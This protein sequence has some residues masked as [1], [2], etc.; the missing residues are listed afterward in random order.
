MQRRSYSY[1]FCSLRK[2]RPAMIRAARMLLTALILAG[3]VSTELPALPVQAAPLKAPFTV[4]TTA[5]TVD[6]SPGNGVCADASG[7]CSLRAAISE[8]N[9]LAGADTITLDAGVYQLT[10]L[11][12]L[13]VNEDG[14]STGDLDI[15][16]SLTLIGSAAGNTIIQAGSNSGDGIDKVIAANPACTDGVNITISN[17]T[18][19]YGRNTQPV[20]PIYFSHT[21]GGVDWCGGSGNGSFTLRDAAVIQNT[22]VNGYGGGLNV[23]SFSG[24]TGTV[25]IYNVTFINNNTLSTTTTSSGGALNIFGDSPVVVITNSSF[26]NNA[27]TYSN[28]GAIFYRPSFGGSLQIDNSFFS[29]NYSR[30]GGAISLEPSTSAST[31]LIQHSVISGNIADEAGGGLSLSPG[32]SSTTPMA[33]TELEIYGNNAGTSGGGIYANG[34]NALLTYSR[35]VYN[36]DSTGGSGLYE[37]ARING[38][39]NV[40]AENNWWG[41]STGP[42]AVPC[43]RAV[44]VGGPLDF[45]PWLRDQL[46]SSISPLAVNQSSTLTS[47]FLTNSENT[48]VPAANLGQIVNQP[49]TWGAT[50]GTLSGTQANILAGGTATGELSGQRSWDCRHLHEGG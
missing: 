42:S 1:F 31:V 9:A 2:L 12:A 24:Y 3:F 26:M 43:D 46:T 28:G 40:R 15:L 39:T 4:N 10:R 19:T 18:I 23:D 30:N 14:N 27:A 50:L 6:A 8:A 17:V 38:P 7:N 13:G 47:S 5:D 11:N 48:A 37:T 49:V 16:S 32:S 45:T 36:T 44:S 34:A 22:T 35:I 29:G 20:D 25:T 33:L 41:C 21:G